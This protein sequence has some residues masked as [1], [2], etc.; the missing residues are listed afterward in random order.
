MENNVDICLC[1]DKTNSMSSFIVRFKKEARK[2]FHDVINILHSKGKTISCFRVRVICFGDCK[3]DKEPMISSPFFILPDSMDQ[4]EDFLKCIEIENDGDAPVDGLEALAYAMKSDWN[5]EG[6]RKRHIIA[7]FTDTSAHELGFGKEEDTYP[8]VG[9][10]KDFGEL[11]EMWGDEDEPGEMNYQAKRLLLFAP[12]V[13]FWHTIANC[14]ENTAIR[15]TKEEA[16]L[17][18]IPDKELL[19]IIAFTIQFI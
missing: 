14:W 9:M 8:K 11:S 5:E 16:G 7:L 15:I 17:G 6:R 10:P 2:L 3:D 12:D 18:D 13:S 1:I 4:L 19:D